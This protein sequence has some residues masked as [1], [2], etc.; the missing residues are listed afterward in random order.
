VELD[1]CIAESQWVVY[2]IHC[3]RGK[4]PPIEIRQVGITYYHN[5][6][7]L[8]ISYHVWRYPNILYHNLPYLEISQYTLTDNYLEGTTNLPNRLHG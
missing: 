7:Y 6:P 2:I 1:D 5:L 4:K 8:V 3:L